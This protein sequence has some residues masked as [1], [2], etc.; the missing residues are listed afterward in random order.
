MRTEVRA[1]SAE[2]KW[3]NRR[4]CSL[5]RGCTHQRAETDVTVP[6]LSELTQCTKRSVPTELEL[7]KSGYFFAKNSTDGRVL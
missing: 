7:S 3:A 1:G 4:M 6:I 2:G 5:Q